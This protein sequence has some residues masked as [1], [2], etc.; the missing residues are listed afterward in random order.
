MKSPQVIEA[1]KRGVTKDQM[2]EYDMTSQDQKMMRRLKEFA[3]MVTED[4]RQHNRIIYMTDNEF[5]SEFVVE[6]DGRGG[7][8]LQVEGKKYRINNVYNLVNNDSEHFVK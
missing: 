1:R 2:L 3:K 6:N 8:V 7:F 5:F 4:Y